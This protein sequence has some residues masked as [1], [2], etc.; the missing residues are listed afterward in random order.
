MEEPGIIISYDKLRILLYNRG[1][2]SC[3]GILMPDREMSEE[4]VLRT[5]HKLEGRGMIEAG[6][7]Y[8][9]ISSE[10]QR[11]ADLIGAPESSYA[12]SDNLTGQ[13][14]YC[15]LSQE[16][17]VV[18][19]NDWNRKNTLIIKRFTPDEFNSWR[20]ELEKE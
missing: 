17:V 16:L 14:Y 19:Q 7:E 1:F 11:I 13:T 4:E 10:M 15:Y 12:F 9:T 5:L 18:T 3:K 2:R 8:F 6:D 20:E